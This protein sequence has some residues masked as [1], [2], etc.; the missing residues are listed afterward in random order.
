MRFSS[1]GSYPYSVDT[2]V[3][4]HVCVRVRVSISLELHGKCMMKIDAWIIKSVCV[5]LGWSRERQR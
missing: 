2:C 3:C 1:C 4:V 5:S